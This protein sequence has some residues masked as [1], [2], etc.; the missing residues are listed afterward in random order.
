MH[1]HATM[2]GTAMPAASPR[3]LRRAI[4]FGLIGF[5]TLVDLFAAQ[6]ILPALAKKY[7][8]LPGEI[9]LAANAGTIGMAIA[10]LAAGA[11]A[12]TVERK[13]G[14]WLS[15]AI[16]AIPTVL[17]ASAPDLDT[18]AALRI[19]QGLCMATAFTLTLAYLGERCN[20]IDAAGALAAFVTGIVA[21]N[22]VGRLSAATVLSYS[23]VE[24]TFYFFAMLNLLGALLTYRV[25]CKT[26]AMHEVD[27]MTPSIVK[28]WWTHFAN[29]AL[30]RSFAIGFLILF[31]FI[32]IFT[33]VNFVL[34]APPINLPQGYLGLVYL[35]FLPAM[36]S[37]P[38]AGKYAVRWGAGETMA[39]T[40]AL[41][42]VGVALAALSNLWAIL[43]GLAIIAVGTFF[44]QAA[45]TGYVSRAA[46]GERGVAG[47]LYLTCYYC[48]G[49]S[50]AAAIGWLFDRF[51]W[52][53][54]LIGNGLALALA[55]LIA[56]SLR[57]RTYNG[58]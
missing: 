55:A 46:T 34:T 40:L 19:A 22:L 1:S 17:L 16:L 18:F 58:V 52:N 3:A 26:H 13:I 12:R 42:V 25:L 29:P 51:G 30:Q 53:A 10:G 20:A 56:W 23:S 9:G 21:S 11:A 47:G 4:T 54:A 6:A 5:L 27:A 8:V 31:A 45:A 44:A 48:G 28:V 2:A 15:L 33:Y 39:V 36:F 50:G 7:G 41:S 32:G 49:L 35:V 57:Q 38:Y 37:T 14:I 24:I 43:T